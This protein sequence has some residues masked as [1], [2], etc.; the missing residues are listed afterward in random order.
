MDLLSLMS[1][2]IQKALKLHQIKMKQQFKKELLKNNFNK[3]FN[4]MKNLKNCK[5]S[6]MK[7]T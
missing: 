4:R 7:I 2:N 6:N 1:N 5:S 3:N